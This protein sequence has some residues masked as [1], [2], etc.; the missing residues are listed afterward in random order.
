MCCRSFLRRRL[1]RGRVEKV[2]A[3]TLMVQGTASSVGK[4]V[5][6]AALC[7]IFRQDGYKVAPFKAQNM[8][9]NSFV[10][11]EGGEIGRAQAVQAEAAGIAPSVYMNPVLLKPEADSK[12]QVI[13]LG[14]VAKTL[15]ASEY[16]RYTP[17]LLKVIEDSLQRLRK[18]YDIIVIE[19]AGSPAEINLKQREIVNMRIARMAQAPVLLAGD[20][21]R[22]GVFASLVGTMELLDAEE[23][24]MVAGFIINKFR[25]DLSLLQPGLA[26]LE[27]R[28]GKSV[29]GVVPYYKD[30]AIAQ[31]DSVYLEERENATGRTAL[32]AAVI[33]LPHISN[34]D[35]FDP[36]EEQGAAVHYVNGSGG[37]AGADLIILPGTKSTISD[38]AYLRSQGLAEEICA[39]AR[40]GTP[41]IGIC[42]GY[43][44]LGRAISDPLHIESEQSSIPGLGL[45]EVETTFSEEKTTTQVKAVVEA[46]NGLLTAMRGMNIEGYEIHMGQ[47]GGTLSPFRVRETPAG[48]ADYADG[49]LSADGMIF[50]T[51]LH[52]LFH[53]ELF[54]RTLL[55][56]LRRLKGL[57]EDNSRFSERDRHYDNLAAHVRGSLKMD[58][59]YRI[60][61]GKGHVR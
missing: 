38:L 16:Y 51:Y 33:R 25:G 17:E 55:N 36:L 13:V 6:V 46:A 24:D 42:G 23:R 37:L 29:L 44:M 58:K 18:A 39:E 31:E 34:Y 54:T 22:G 27:E 47:T 28:T 5:L 11:P 20:I 49:A 41:V 1:H 53:N 43:Q 40:K 15:Q 10:T 48:A 7:R 9:L 32:T 50:G 60:L 14:K 3:K 30:I 52:G 26:M 2:A 4:S 61:M 8:A 45:L 12:S 35:D 59:I 19:G 21:D 56:A 57:P